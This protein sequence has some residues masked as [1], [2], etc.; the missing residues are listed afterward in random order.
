M[1]DLN[2]ESAVEQIAENLEEELGR[3]PTQAEVEE[4]VELRQVS[5]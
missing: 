4:Q 5:E 1:S 3:T 2:H